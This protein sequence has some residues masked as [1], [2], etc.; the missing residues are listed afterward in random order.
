MVRTVAA[1]TE[2]L[3]QAHTALREDLQELA[4]ASR[5]DSLASLAALR[6]HLSAT[7]AH[8]TEHF[9]AEEED[10][11]MEAVRSREPRLERVLDQLAGEHSELAQALKAIIDQAAAATTLD[12]TLRGAIRNWIERVR[13]HEV[14]ENDLVQDVFTLDISAED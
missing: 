7:Q 14:R 2:A 11:Y 3:R 12:E 9:R 5:T 1:V 4:A 6:V 8:I 13:Q 10:G